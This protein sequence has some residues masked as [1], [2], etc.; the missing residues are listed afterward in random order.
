[1]NSGG[2][3]RSSNLVNYFLRIDVTT[4]NF[5]AIIQNK[6]KES[7]NSYKKLKRS[8]WTGTR[9]HTVTKSKYFDGHSSLSQ[10]EEAI[11]SIFNAKLFLI[12]L[13]VSNKCPS[14]DTL[15]AP[16][17]EL[18]QLEKFPREISGKQ[19]LRPFSYKSN[20]LTCANEVIITHIIMRYIESSV[21]PIFK[22]HH[23][24]LSCSYVTVLKY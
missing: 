2:E 19:E 14:N 13:A 6:G 16:F 4:I 1:M 17:L 8:R 12:R 15:G 20:M 23:P 5:Y 24:W 7:E 18:I 10:S 22:F 11:L 9:K 3:G 21:P